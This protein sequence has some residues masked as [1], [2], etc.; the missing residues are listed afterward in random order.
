MCRT[1]SDVLLKCGGTVQSLK[2]PSRV[3][4]KLDLMVSTQDDP[5]QDPSNIADQI[6]Q[7]S[8]RQEVLER[9]L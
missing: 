3:P 7:S 2:D 4:L 9:A 5:F 1:K 8:T 6:P